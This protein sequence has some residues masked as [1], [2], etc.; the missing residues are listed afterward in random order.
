MDRL[1]EELAAAGVRITHHMFAQ[2][3][4]GFLHYKPAETVRQALRMIEQ[5]LLANLA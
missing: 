4:H 2:T 5:H 3:D 1:A